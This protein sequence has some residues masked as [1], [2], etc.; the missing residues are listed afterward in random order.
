MYTRAFSRHFFAPFVYFVPFRNLLLFS[1]LFPEVFVSS[2]TKI[3]SDIV[4]ARAQ[5]PYYD[6]LGLNVG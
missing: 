4:C 1:D 6:H 5:L 3:E 2:V